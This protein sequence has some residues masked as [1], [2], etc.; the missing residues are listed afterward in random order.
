MDEALRETA[1]RHLRDAVPDVI[2]IYLFGSQAQG[3]VRADSDIDL[4]ILPSA[5]IDP[6]ERWTVQEDLSIALRRDVDLVD[7]RAASTVMRMQVIRQS[8][9]LYE[10]DTTARQEFEMYTYSSYALLNEERAAI[11]QD[12]QERGRIHGR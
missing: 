4:A 2:A 5:P 1:V 6:V 3:S 8:Q 12:I 9:L 10:S 7:L 11:L